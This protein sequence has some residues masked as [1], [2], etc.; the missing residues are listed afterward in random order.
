MGVPKQVYGFVSHERIPPNDENDLRDRR[1]SS[2]GTRRDSSTIGFADTPVR[3]VHPF[4]SSPYIYLCHVSHGLSGADLSSH[5]DST[6]GTLADFQRD[7]LCLVPAGGAAPFL[8]LPWCARL[9]TTSGRE[10]TPPPS[11]S[12]HALLR[13]NDNLTPQTPDRYYSRFSDRYALATS[14]FPISRLV[15]YD[16]ATI[17]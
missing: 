11:S 3:D 14:I 2:S 5:V 9:D 6:K 4:Y 10:R 7:V 8:P 12:F 1:R 17:R 15:R 13:I 16:F